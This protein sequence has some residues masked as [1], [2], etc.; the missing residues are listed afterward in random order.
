MAKEKKVLTE[1]KTAEN[2][3]KE[4]SPKGTEK[5]SYEQLE[6]LASQYYAQSKRLNEALNEVQN[7]LLEATTQLEM[8]QKNEF[9]M[10]ID[11]LWRVITLE[12]SNEVFTNEFLEKVTKE[13]MA[14]MYPPKPTEEPKNNPTQN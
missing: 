4:K 3:I 11:W 13:F 1:E 8:F 14:R 6:Q 9:W 7:K 10:R 12:G 2:K 5:L